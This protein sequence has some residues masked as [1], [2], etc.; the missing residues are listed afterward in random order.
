[1]HNKNLGVMYLKWCL[2]DTMFSVMLPVKMKNIEYVRDAYIFQTEL[3][4]LYE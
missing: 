3:E 2:H 1:M 4:S